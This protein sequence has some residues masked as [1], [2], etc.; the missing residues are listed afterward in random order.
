MI[1]N[2]ITIRIT[3]RIT[4][5]ITSG[6]PTASHQDHQH[7]DHQQDHQQDHNQDRNRKWRALSSGGRTPPPP[8]LATV[9]LPT[10]QK[11]KATGA[12]FDRPQTRPTSSH[13]VTKVLCMYNTRPFPLAIPAWRPLQPSSSHPSDLL[14]LA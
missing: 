14:C 13:T 4:N 8:R 2:K 3:I 7:Q 6:S 11:P 10:H 1:T 5:S 9:S 12:G